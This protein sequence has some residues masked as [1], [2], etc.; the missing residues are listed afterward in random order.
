MV[1]VIAILGGSLVAAQT[2]PVPGNSA[3][4]STDVRRET[5]ELLLADVKTKSAATLSVMP[6]TSTSGSAPTI[7]DVYVVRD[8]KSETLVIP[9]FDP[10]FQALV[11]TGTLMRLPGKVQTTFGAGFT[12]AAGSFATAK[13]KLGFSW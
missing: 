5:T 2:L 11:R 4:P 10:P 9:R 12:P 13:F 3:T 1:G 6:K 7:M 8:L